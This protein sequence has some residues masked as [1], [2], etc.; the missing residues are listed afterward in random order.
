MMARLGF[1][2]L[3]QIDQPFAGEIVQKHVMANAAVTEE[4]VQALVN[5]YAKEVSRQMLFSFAK[6]DP[7]ASARP[8]GSV[9]ET[10]DRSRQWLETK[11]IHDQT[12]VFDAV[13]RVSG[14][15]PLPDRL[16]VEAAAKNVHGKIR[17]RQE[18]VNKVYVDALVGILREPGMSKEVFDDYAMA[19]HAIDRNRMIQAR[20]VGKAGGGVAGGRGDGVN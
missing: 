19:L 3:G 18:E 9:R 12:P 20:S 5:H 8:G 2:E 16:N 1:R 13:R 17:A 15:D 11:F 7:V 10:M 14:N 4:K 6:G